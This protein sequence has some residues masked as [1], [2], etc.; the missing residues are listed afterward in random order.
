MFAGWVGWD[1]SLDAALGQPIPKAIGVIGAVGQELSWWRDSRQ[2]IA[3]GRQVVTIAGCDQE[4]DGS[5]AIFSQRVDFGG[6]AATRAA[7]R[8][9][10]VPPFA[11]AAER[12]ALMWVESI[13]I[14]PIRPLEPV[15]A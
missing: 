11:P 14:V 10:E 3:S 8:L 2:K 5:A 7:D 13:D 1:H 15:S 4:G 6:A 9:F 12:W